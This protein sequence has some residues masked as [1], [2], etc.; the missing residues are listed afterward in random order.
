MTLIARSLSNTHLFAV[1]ALLSH[2][3]TPS[4]KTN[5]EA[6]ER[7]TAQKL[8]EQDGSDFIGPSTNW[9]YRNSGRWL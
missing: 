7:L 4:D 3:P 6:R 2:A 8:A 5:A 9:K 1:V